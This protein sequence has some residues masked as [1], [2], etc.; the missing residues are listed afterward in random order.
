MRIEEIAQEDMRCLYLASQCS[1][2]IPLSVWSVGNLISRALGLL[3]SETSDSG[4]LENKY[5][6]KRRK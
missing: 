1:E 6:N 2:M 4:I 5:K 3:Q